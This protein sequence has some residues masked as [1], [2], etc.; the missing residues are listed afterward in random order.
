MW[1]QFPTTGVY[2]KDQICISEKIINSPFKQSTPLWQQGMRID[3][4]N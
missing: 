2:A 4:V 3:E 1:H